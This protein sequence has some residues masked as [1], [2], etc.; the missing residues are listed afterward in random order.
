MTENRH[1]KEDLSVDNVH[2]LFGLTKPSQP[3]LSA[4]GAEPN[5]ESLWKDFEVMWR[6]VP[7]PMKGC[8]TTTTYR[9]N[10]EKNT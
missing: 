2:T 4:S 9:T 6:S 7:L 3:R 10:Q 8:R 1:I 5:P